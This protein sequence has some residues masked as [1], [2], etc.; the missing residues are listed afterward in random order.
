MLN[1]LKEQVW[2]AN[3]QLVKEGLV[4]QT[5]GNASGIDRASDAV[6]IKPSGLS[7][8]AMKPEDMV[9]VSLESGRVLEGN[10]KPSSDTPTHLVLYRAFAD[11]GGIAHTHSLCATAWAQARCDLPA[12]GTTHADYFRGAIPCTRLLREKEIR[13]DYEEYTG[14]VIVERFIR[15][16][17]AEIPGI[18]VASHGPFTWGATPAL[19]VRNAVVL[20]HVARLASETLRINYSI[21]SM[22]R[23]LLDRHF[24]RKH[25]TDAYYGQR[26]QGPPGQ[27][28]G[29]QG[30]SGSGQPKRGALLQPWSSKGFHFK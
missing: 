14:N 30:Q 23:S 2:Q 27:D 10:F 8:D 1:E 28:Q 5:W 16:D 7:Y 19:A 17:P 22:Q 18:L 3:L 13:S 11:I 6:V 9:V 25:G 29:S 26:G 4:V 20:E 15:L 24:T 21:N 12:L